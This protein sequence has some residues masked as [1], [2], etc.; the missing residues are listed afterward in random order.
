MNQN[1]S[2]AI[3]IKNTVL[4]I[5]HAKSAIFKRNL[6]VL[7][8]PRSP[9]A[10]EPSLLTCD[11]TAKKKIWRLN[12]G[13]QFTKKYCRENLEVNKYVRGRSSVRGERAEK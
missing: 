5:F 10:L 4:N 11:P 7:L 13:Y 6:G 2:F 1:R 12:A 9:G 8:V 3:R